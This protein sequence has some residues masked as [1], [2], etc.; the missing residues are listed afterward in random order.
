MTPGRHCP[1]HYRYTPAA[2]ARPADFRAETLYVV[3]GLY[4][5]RPALDAVLTLCER[6]AGPVTLVFNGDFNW[7]NVD[8]GSF[9]A[10]NE[11]V[12]QYRVLR[13][14]VETELASDDP[15]AGCGCAYPEWVDAAVVARSNAIMRQLQSVAR[16]FPD[17]CARLAAAPMHRVAAVGDLR[18]GIVHGDAESLAGWRFSQEA[19]DDHTQDAW[20]S[21][22]FEQARVRIFACSHTCLPVLRRIE[23]PTGTGI[24]VN[25]GAAGMPN[26]RG[27]RHGL[28]TRI[29]TRPARGGESLYGVC[30]DD[31]HIDALPLCYDPAAWEQAFLANW[32][33]GSPAYESYYSRIVQGPDYAIAQAVQG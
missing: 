10:I 24:V 19:L 16:D 12:L 4:G 26:F 29:A 21:A 13:G 25:N 28:I 32:P 33:V 2:L 9:V 20:L 5:N 15:A 17:L 31:V 1:L 27:T 14:N 11:T 6:E 7:F 18:V 3:G 22:A 23:L 30:V 8:P